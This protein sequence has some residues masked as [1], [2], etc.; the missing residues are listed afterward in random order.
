[1]VTWERP[2]DSIFDKYCVKHIREDTGETGLT[3]E[4]E[5]EVS[6]IHN[7]YPGATYTIEVKNCPN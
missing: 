1:M 4:T 3:N 7:L 6:K 2:L 5:T